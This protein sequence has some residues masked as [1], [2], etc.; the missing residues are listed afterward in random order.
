MTAAIG[1]DAAEALTQ[2]LGGRRLYVRRDPGANHPI[3]VAIG[4]GPAKILGEQF[5][6]HYV[7]VPLNKAL[8]ARI[9]ELR[10]QGVQVSRIASMLRCTE[11]RVYQVQAEAKE[12]GQQ[13]AHQ[14]D[15]YD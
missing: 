1:K 15:L 12:A 7:D 14:P 3:T 11:R 10:G 9:L 13:T 2:A 4:P 8:Q 5:H 6:G